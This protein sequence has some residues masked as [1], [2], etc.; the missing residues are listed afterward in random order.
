MTIGRIFDGAAG[1]GASTSGGQRRHARCLRER[2][3]TML[4]RVPRCPQ[5]CFGGIELLERDLRVR[6][7][8]VRPDQVHVSKSTAFHEV[9]AAEH[10]H[11]LGEPLPPQAA[12][13]AGLKPRNRRLMYPRQPLEVAL[14][15]PE[16]HPP[17]AHGRADEL[18]AALRIRVPHPV[19]RIIP[20]HVVVVAAEPA[21]LLIDTGLG[22]CARRGCRACASRA[23]GRD[24][25]SIV[26]KRGT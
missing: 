23:R 2:R 9:E 10:A 22:A 13:I 12:S 21:P 16:L 17:P 8:T 4:D 20:G 25:R 11:D 26:I 15:Q 7:E 19:V 6:R 5:H 3:S 1:L 18:E 24:M 14:R